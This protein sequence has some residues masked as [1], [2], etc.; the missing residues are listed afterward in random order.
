MSATRRFGMSE[1][2]PDSRFL[3]VAILWLVGF[4][5]WFYTFE[6]PNNRPI[7]RVDLWPE[8]PFLLMDLVDPPP[9][10]QNADPSGWRFLP[11]RFDILAIA[12]VMLA[13]AY[14]AGSLLLRLLGRW[15]TDRIE[16]TVI[17]IRTGAFRAIVI[18]TRLR[19]G[20]LVVAAAVRHGDRCDLPGRNR[21]ASS[22]A[23][24]R[25]TRK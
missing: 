22:R 10:A 20:W 7:R 24:K 5:V 23:S 11:Q 4:T 2:K 21:F 8:I 17:R 12:G 16:Q 18:H 15:I 3:A 19:F 25:T 13:G 14:A 6:L 1:T 9:P